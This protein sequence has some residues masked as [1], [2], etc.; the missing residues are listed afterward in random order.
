[1]KFILLYFEHSL[2]L[3]LPI[4]TK[5]PP[6]VHLPKLKNYISQDEEESIHS[7]I[8]K[9]SS[10]DHQTLS[11]E[12][13]LDVLIFSFNSPNGPLLQVS[14]RS[15]CILESSIFYLQILQPFI[16][17]INLISHFNIKWRKQKLREEI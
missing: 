2:L 16:I 9:I 5:Q 12:L 6:I 10:I 17:Q 14:R 8:S 11:L 7:K 1:M 4:K 13:I 3:L 15:S